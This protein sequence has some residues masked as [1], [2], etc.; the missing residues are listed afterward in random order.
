MPDGDIS[1]V[2]IVRHGM[3]DLRLVPADGWRIL[4]IAGTANVVSKTALAGL[5]G[6]K[7]LLLQVAMLFAVS[8]AGGILM[9]VLL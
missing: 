1:V 2:L 6:G 7:R 9:L 8:L 4:V 5:F 3:P